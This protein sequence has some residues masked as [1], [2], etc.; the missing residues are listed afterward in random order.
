M[1]KNKQ[2]FYVFYILVP[3]FLITLLPQ[4]NKHKLC[5][6]TNTIKNVIV[7]TVKFR[8]THDSLAMGFLPEYSAPL[9]AEVETGKCSDLNKHIIY[10]EITTKGTVTHYII[11][12]D[13]K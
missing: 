4:C 3:F 2:Y 11:K 10:D 8:E 12:C 13:N 6:C 7:D 5:Q 1:K 9:G